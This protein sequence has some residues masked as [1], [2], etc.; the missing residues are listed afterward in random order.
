MNLQDTFKNLTYN[1]P[2]ELTGELDVFLDKMQEMDKNFKAEIEA[3]IA[4]MHDSINFIL[5]KIQEPAI[6]INDFGNIRLFW[7]NEDN[8][9]VGLQFLG[10]SQVQYVIFSKQ[11]DNEILNTCHGRAHINT[12]KNLIEAN[13]LIHMVYH[14]EKRLITAAK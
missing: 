11:K 4:S 9:Q 2:P 7:C 6:F 10:E 13:G 12:V 5:T 3:N 8:E 14:H 1:F